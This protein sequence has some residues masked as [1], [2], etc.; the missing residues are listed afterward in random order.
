MKI[1]GDKVIPIMDQ[2]AAV[3]PSDAAIA[4]VVHAPDEDGMHAD[5]YVIENDFHDTWNDHQRLLFFL[6][7]LFRR[8]NAVAEETEN[9]AKLDERLAPLLAKTHVETGADRDV[10]KAW[11][12][13][14]PEFVPTG[15]PAGH[16][17]DT[18]GHIPAGDLGYDYL[19]IPHSDE[20]ESE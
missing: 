5:E 9:K 3:L 17:R 19:T 18:T 1:D 8:A 7:V 15:A 4:L 16:E 14:A 20:E 11:D 6:G 2:L 13:A 12:L 10:I